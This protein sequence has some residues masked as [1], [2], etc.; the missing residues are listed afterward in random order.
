MTMNTP[1]RERRG[2]SAKGKIS[3]EGGGSQ[4]PPFSLRQNMECKDVKKEELFEEEKRMRRLRFIVDLTQAILMQSDLTMREAF[5][6]LGNTKKAALLLFPDK[7]AVYELLYAPRFR[8]IV[9]ER[10]VIPGGLAKKPR[11]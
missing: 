4:S 10:F 11:K 9:R 7:E 3:H 8:R 6:L 5:D 1:E 2:S